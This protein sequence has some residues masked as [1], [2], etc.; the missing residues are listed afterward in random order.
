[1]QK[2]C[3]IGR[4]IRNDQIKVFR[5]KMSD[6]HFLTEN[7]GTESWILLWWWISTEGEFLEARRRKHQGGEFSWLKRWS[8]W[9]ASDAVVDWFLVAHWRKHLVHLLR[10]GVQWKF[11]TCI[12]CLVDNWWAVAIPRGCT[13][14][15]LDCSFVWRSCNCVLMFVLMCNCVLM[16]TSDWCLRGNPHFSMVSLAKY[17]WENVHTGQI[18]YLYGWYCQDWC[19]IGREGEGD[20]RATEGFSRRRVIDECAYCQYRCWC[21]VHTIDW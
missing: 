21:Q 14:R 8:F 10:W 9:I 17:F 18:K 2:L 4:T 20:A 11:L 1:M 6:F 15:L 5:N 19:L 12:G 16:L 7:T 13:D 3:T